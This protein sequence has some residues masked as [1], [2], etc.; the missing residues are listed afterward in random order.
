LFKDKSQLFGERGERQKC[1]PALAL[2]AEAPFCL[3]F[4]FLFHQL[5]KERRKKENASFSIWLL[6]PSYLFFLHS[7]SIIHTS[8]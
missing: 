3:D 8:Q 6:A 5:E 4:L 7:K 2:R 1:G